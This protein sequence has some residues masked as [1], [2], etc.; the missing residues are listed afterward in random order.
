MRAF[1]LVVAVATQLFAG[2]HVLPVKPETVV[3]GYY[4]AASPPALRVKSG[5]TVEVETLGV[6]RPAALEGLGV[7]AGRIQPQL[8]AVMAAHPQARGHFLTGPVYVEEAAPGDTLEV[9][10]L[11]VRM[12]LDYAYNAMGANGVLAGQFRVGTNKLVAL[13]RVRMVAQF[14]SGVNVPLRPFFGSMGVAPPPDAGRRPSSPPWIHAGNMDNRELVA[15]TTVYIPVHTT[16]A[17]FLVGDGHAAQGDGE[18]DQTGLETSLTG[19]FRFTVRK[20]R[21]LAWPRAETATHFIAMGFDEDLN[22]AVRIATDEAVI[23]LT[24]LGG[25]SRADAYV[26]ASIAVDLR[27][28]QLVDGNKG[29]HAMI[30]KTLFQP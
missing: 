15:G 4:D 5:D 27:I 22:K 9:N 29:V 20:N 1:S 12:N 26:L 25:M 10:I 24:E 7:P 18:V 28:T 13:D 23:W 21:K 8:K 17:L 14:A 30:P 19:T 6:A 16:G 2:H 11:D 3:V